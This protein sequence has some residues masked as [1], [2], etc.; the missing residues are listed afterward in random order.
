MVKNP[1]LPPLRMLFLLLTIAAVAHAQDTRNVTEP[2]VPPSCI[3][4]TA[5]L[6]PHNGL[7]S[8]SEERHHRDNARIEEAFAK[9]PA[10]QAVV[11][12]AGGHGKTVF[13]IGPLHLREGVTLVVSKGAALW[14]SRD[15]REY[16]NAPH[17]CG[18]VAEQRG[19]GCKP[20]IL[21][22]HASHSGIMGEG[23]IDGRG[24][25]K[26]LDEKETWWEL[27]HRAKVEDANQ[28]VSR[29]LVVRNSD[30]FTL[31]G[32]TLRNSPNCH[33]ST[34]HVH[35]FTAWGVK[36]DTPKWARNTDGID[37]SSDTSDI[38]IA[39]SYI[40]SGDDNISPKSSINVG[41]VTHMT[42]VDTHFYNGHGFGIGSQTSAGLNHIRVDGLTIDGS[43][44][45][46]RIKS[47]KSRG[48]L[49]EDVQFRNVCIRN[50]PNPIVINPYYTTFD[51]THIPLYR[52][53]TLE[54]VHALTPGSVILRGLDEQHISQVALK[55]VTV[56]GL[57]AEDLHAE[58]AALTIHGG[59]LGQFFKENKVGP[60]VEINEQNAS[61]SLPYACANQFPPFP[62]NRTAPVSAELIPPADKTFYV[63]ADGTGDYYSV[64][65]AINKVPA[66]GGLVMVAPGTYREQVVIRQ[67]HV[68]LMSS[69]PDPSKT[70]IVDD[71][72]QGT[73]GSKE[74]Y[75]TVH[76][77]G[78]DFHARNITFE[79]DF[80]RTHEQAYSGSQA[81]AL[82]L[83]GDRNILSNVHILA[84]Q[85]TLYIGAKGC[86]QAG[87]HPGTNKPPCVAQPTRSYFTHC[88]VAGNV[89]YIYGDG[90]AVF[91]DCEIHN[92]VHAAGGFLTAQGKYLPDMQ[93]T[94][95]FNHCRATAE[96]GVTNV[97]LG[98]P[99]RPYAS[100]VFLNTE[101]GAHIVPEGWREWHPGE[102]HY[103]DTAFFAE[104]HSTGPGANPA[105]RE[106]KSHQLTPQEA[107]HY[108][109]ERFLAGKDHWNP[110]TELK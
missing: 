26:L 3:T 87:G 16:D 63:A 12:R 99:W 22:D 88:V 103:L 58:Y 55:N 100:V 79:N 27:A 70:I 57:T 54:N 68:T 106:P 107:T 43:D 44:N 76:V 13:L 28:S 93:S 67:S 11:L 38:T 42:V 105:A 50:S 9:C 102:T 91:E 6:A 82:N 14:A 8:D 34:E 39:H 19:P 30:D 65:S 92:T 81:Q 71:T 64:Q 96:P 49:V 73:R 109:T 66:E 74:S 78:D 84:N 47:D 61:S 23:V 98:R 69:N 86:G 25:T 31:Y 85:D 20:L 94:F 21:A 1:A 56:D 51:G 7:L 5:Q 75:A 33:V 37:P 17:S 60:N 24:G 110:K 4:L 2:H 77:L 80:N 104:Y 41:P 62:E 29:I 97:Y 53:I 89:D 59:N 10:G 90:N 36:I 95:V 72:S 18:I 52:D 40:R 45:G 46:L 101:L 15:P 48:G 32:I 108:E 35:G 83:D